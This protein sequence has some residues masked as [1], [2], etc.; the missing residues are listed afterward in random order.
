MYYFETH[1]IFRNY[2]YWMNWFQTNVVEKKTTVL[3]IA[4]GEDPPEV[5]VVT[6]T[7]S[8]ENQLRNVSGRYNI[9]FKKS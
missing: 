2:I 5:V 1:C 7:L 4:I 6:P 8:L 9:L 3:S